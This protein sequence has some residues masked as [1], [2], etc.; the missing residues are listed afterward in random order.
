[1]KTIGYVITFTFLFS[2]CCLCTAGEPVLQEGVKLQAAGK[3]INGQVGHLVPTVVDWN[4]DG[5]KDLIVGQFGGG[6]I[7]LYLN[8]GTDA[9]PVLDAVTY[10]KADGKPISLSAG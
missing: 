8:K 10:L 9:A 5:K 6:S 4:G 2:L 3:D 1:M 7:G